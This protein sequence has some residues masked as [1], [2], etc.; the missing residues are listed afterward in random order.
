MKH[1]ILFTTCLLSVLALAAIEVSGT[2]S[3]TWTAADNPYQIVGDISIPAG[4]VLTIQPG[5]MVEAMGN[6]RINA[7]GS[8]QAIGTPADSIYFQ[9]GQVPA[10]NLWKGIR[11]DNPGAESNFQHIVMEYAE[12]GINAVNTP[13]EVSYSRFSY[14]QRGMHLYGIGNA[15]PPVMNVHHNLVEHS[16]QNGIL[17]PQNS[18]AWVHHNEVRYNG[19]VTQ[20]YGAI[21]LSNQSQ[22]GQNNPIIEHNYIHHN[23]KQGITAW[24]VMAT[25]AINPTIRHNHIE[26]N[27]TGIYLLYSSGIVHHNTIINNFIAGD[28]NSGAGIMIGGATSHPY[29]AENIIAGNFTGLYITSNA[30]PVLGN[31]ADTNPWAYGRN[32]IQNNIDESNLLHSVYCDSYPQA[33]N[34]IKAE[35]NDWGVYTAAE[36]AIG[37]N[38]HNDNPALPTVDFEPWFEQEEEGYIL[39][40]TIG[41]PISKQNLELLLKII[42]FES[43]EIL[44]QYDVEEDQFGVHCTVERPFYAYVE[45]SYASNYW[46]FAGNAENP[47]LFTPDGED[48]DLGFIIVNQFTPYYIYE[49]GEAQTI[50][51]REIFPI[52]KRYLHFAPEVVDYFYDEGDYRYIY[53]HKYLSD[54]NWQEVL[55][56]I[57]QIYEKLY[58]QAHN[59]SWIMNY[60]ADGLPI[61]YSVTAFMDNDAGLSFMIRNPDD[62]IYRQRFFGYSFSYDKSYLYDANTY[63][64]Y[65][66]STQHIDASHWKEYLHPMETLEIPEF[67]I[68][69]FNTCGTTGFTFDMWWQAPGHWQHNYVY[70]DIFMQGSDAT[71]KLLATLDFAQNYYQSP[72]LQASGWQDFWV[73]AVSETGPRVIS[74]RKAFEFP[75]STADL[76][77]IPEIN[78]YPNPLSF[79]RAEGLSISQKGLKQAEIKIYNLRGQL[80]HKAP[81]GKDEHLWQGKDMKNQAVGSGIYFLMIES[82]GRRAIHRKISLIK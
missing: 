10:T 30:M 79:S 5:V 50:E 80:V 20:C 37:I 25:N 46:G 60:V 38:D 13:I 65:Y 40:G 35:N 7:E 26:A 81:L 47:Q 15:N 27:L 44:A 24:D 41:I 31:M 67:R 56:G 32:V 59:E 29:I 12:Y 4:S 53:K 62:S 73:E 78:I 63:A 76:V 51:G 49:K 11:L 77:Q 75:H 43:G 16:A 39:R 21:Q 17:I 22:G 69:G 66:L 1:L 23:Y 68:R 61:Q 8:I 82:E 2:V 36:I 9:N 55:C 6:Y 64:N 48:I 42:D 71:P 14:N 19:T 52:A 34:I 70:Y 28:A 33:N 54:G 74:E 58:N 45:P 18:N 3:G 57:G 72:C